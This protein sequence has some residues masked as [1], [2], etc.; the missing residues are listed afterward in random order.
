MD[1]VSRYSAEFLHHGEEPELVPSHTIFFT[2][3]NFSCVYCQNW[4]ISTAPNR[5]IPILPEEFARKITLQR[6][7][8]SK[9]VNF[10]TPTPHTHTIL[11]ILNALKVNVPVV[12]NSN[13]YYSS[14]V[15]KLLEGVVD[16]YLGILDTEMM[17]APKN[18]QMF[19]IAGL[20]SQEISRPHTQGVKYCCASLLFQTIS[21]A[22]QN[23]SL[24]GQKRISRR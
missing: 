8:G 6:A 22:V 12:W 4:Q 15:A 17:S 5:G 1:A 14:E 3:C 13:M 11:K 20:S 19:R 2:G 21:S 23:L 10:V 24:N 9:N 7:Y 18:I 16:V